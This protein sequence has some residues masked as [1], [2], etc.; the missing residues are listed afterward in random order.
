MASSRVVVMLP[1]ETKLKLQKM[2]GNG[3]SISGFIRYLIE[4]EIEEREKI[5]T[6]KLTAKK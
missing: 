4:Q 2:K 6:P 1:I 5:E 3:Y